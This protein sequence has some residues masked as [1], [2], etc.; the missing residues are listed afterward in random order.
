MKFASETIDVVAGGKAEVKLQLERH[1]ADFQNEITISPLSF[2]GGFNMP[3]AKFAG[4]QTE[5]ALTIEVQNGRP[6]GEYTIAVLGQA[7]VPF[8]KDP[9]AKDRPN[10]LVSLPSQPLTL[11]VRAPEKK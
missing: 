1:W 10:T 9:L 5:V 11:R 4:T 8:S 2:P 6:P 3:N 7:Q